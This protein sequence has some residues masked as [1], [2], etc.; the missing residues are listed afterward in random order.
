MSSRGDFCKTKGRQTKGSKTKGM[1]VPDYA[2]IVASNLA[3]LSGFF[4]SSCRSSSSG[5]A[6]P[7]VQ[8]N[9]FLPEVCDDQK[10]VILF[11]KK[12]KTA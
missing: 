11:I 4:I 7:F 1:V 8:W 2:I 9:R 12:E 6:A 10:A 3:L 5:R